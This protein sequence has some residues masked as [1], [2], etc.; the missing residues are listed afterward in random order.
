MKGRPKLKGPKDPE[1]MNKSFE[2][3]QIKKVSW[4]YWVR[5][6]KD[7]HPEF[8][9]I[10]EPIKIWRKHVHNFFSNT[11]FGSKLI[12]QLQDPEPFV[13][14]FRGAVRKGKTTA[15]I[16]LADWINNTLLK[17]NLKITD[18][19]KYD[20]QE[21]FMQMFTLEGLPFPNDLNN[22]KEMASFMQRLKEQVAKGYSF[23]YPGAVWVQDEAPITLNPEGHHVE[24]EVHDLNSLFSIRGITLANLILTGVSQRTLADILPQAQHI[25]RM[26]KRGT[27]DW[28]YTYEKDGKR[29]AKIGD[30]YITQSFPP[31]CTE[32]ANEL[33]KPE[34]LSKLEIVT[35]ILQHRAKRLARQKQRQIKRPQMESKYGKR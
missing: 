33:A 25:L 11:K 7:P 12:S 21:L 34:L 14:I 1:I 2:R 31:L 32:L 8:L 5:H 18:Y 9:V 29:N 4:N 20:A 35:E 16:V 6:R 3:R 17:Y 19:M 10:D 30:N 22:Q 24:D 27:A 23:K 26:I 28:K 13:I 15:A